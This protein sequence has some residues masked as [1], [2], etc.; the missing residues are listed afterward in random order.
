MWESD[1][2][3]MLFALLSKEFYLDTLGLLIS[4]HPTMFGM[5]FNSILVIFPQVHHKDVQLHIFQEFGDIQ[6]KHIVR[7]PKPSNQIEK[8]KHRTLCPGGRFFRISWWKRRSYRASNWNLS[9]LPR[10]APSAVDWGFF[11]HRVVVLKVK[12]REIS[13]DSSRFFCSK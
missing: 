4:K 5:E 9:C 7:T 10:R 3:C 11:T 13:K 2:L 6:V 8:K 12:L 1:A